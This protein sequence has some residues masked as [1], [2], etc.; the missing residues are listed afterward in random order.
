MARRTEIVGTREMKWKCTYCGTTNGGFERICKSCG[1]P[2]D[3]AIKF[4]QNPDAEILTTEEFKKKRN[5]DWI[6]SFCDSLNSDTVDDCHFCGASREDSEKNYREHKAELA[7]K[8]AKQQ[9]ECD[10]V[11]D[12][13]REPE[14]AKVTQ[15]SYKQSY[16]SNNYTYE[17]ARSYKK[18]K[19]FLCDIPWGNIF[20]V[21]AGF[22]AVVMVI[23][24]LV[25]LFSPKYETVTIQDFSWERSICIEK[26]VT[27]QDEGWSIPYGGR[28]LDKDWK[29]KE[30]KKFIDHY[31][32]EEYQSWEVVDTK[33]EIEEK[34]EIVAYEEKEVAQYWEENDDGTESLIVEY[35]DV[36][37]YDW[38]PYEKEVDVYDYVTRTKKVEVYGYEDIYDWWYTYEYEK[39][40]TDYYATSSGND[41][42]PYWKEFTLKEKQQENGRS[43]T[44]SAT[45]LTEDNETKTYTFDYNTWKA[46]KKGEAVQLKVSVFGH[47]ELVVDN[48]VVSTG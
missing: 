26:E 17:P 28:E 37:I 33:I 4:E 44:Y 46:L 19:S 48:E 3:K 32:D 39:W 24:A 12:D 9:S 29:F 6:C 30:T 31:E 2:R 42:S 38:V 47:A 27:L 45:V 40:V 35:D 13:F 41:Q 18:E 23:M 43:E 21:T 20:K 22:L 8:K 5:P 1:T 36:P 15:Q 16:T 10:S 11:I 25:W 14:P 7:Q 34:W